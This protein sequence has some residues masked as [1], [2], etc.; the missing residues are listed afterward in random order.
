MAYVLN[1][2]CASCYGP[3]HVVRIH[4]P[5]GRTVDWPVCP[6]C[7]TCRHLDETDQPPGPQR[8]ALL[9]EDGQPVGSIESVPLSPE[10]PERPERHLRAVP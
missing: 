6:V 3:M 5:N 10:R 1:P 7:L 9:N 8:V 4:H 2:F